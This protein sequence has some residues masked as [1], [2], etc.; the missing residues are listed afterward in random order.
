MAITS[1][2]KRGRLEDAWDSIVSPDTLRAVLRTNERL[3]RAA[4]S[5]GL[6]KRSKGNGHEVDFFD[7][8][9]SASSI[10]PLEIAELYRSLIDE[11]DTALVFLSNCALYGLDAFRT[12][13][14]GFPNAVT[15]VG[16]PATLDTTGRF[17]QLCLQFGVV[18]NTVIGVAVNED[19]VF[20]WLMWHCVPVLESH[21]DYTLMRV[22]EGNQF[23]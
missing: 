13:L 8:S 9:S 18:A 16:S 7:P 23:L 19:T 3:A 2:E 10:T 15:A 20:L 14:E 4:Y 22:A 1:K 21:G 17:A 11:Y 12:E 5:G 6:V